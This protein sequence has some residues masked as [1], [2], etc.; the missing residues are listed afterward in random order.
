ME[1]LTNATAAIPEFSLAGKILPAKIVSCYD[2]DTFYAVIP[3]EGSLYKFN[4]RVS[5]YDTPEM[6]P[7][8]NKPERD[9]EKARAVKAKHALLSHICSGIPSLDITVTNI[10]L[11]SIVAK[12][13][14]I[15]EME[16]KEFDKYGR[17]LVD[18]ILSDKTRVSNWM[19][20]KGYGYVY[21]GGT[22]DISFATKTT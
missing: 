7:P 6:K 1:A 12:N 2:G 4:C 10:E 15:I 5:G 11:D 21:S 14:R 19:V 16:C 8:K 9:L 17:V 20:E 3:L 22:K 18:V 13:T